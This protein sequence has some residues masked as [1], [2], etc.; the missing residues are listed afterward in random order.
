MEILQ[1]YIE[2]FTKKLWK[3][4]KANY[5][6]DAAQF[7]GYTKQFRFEGMRGFYMETFLTAIKYNAI[8]TI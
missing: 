3:N 6:E 4:Y 2:K 5:R 7:K 1:N 8:K